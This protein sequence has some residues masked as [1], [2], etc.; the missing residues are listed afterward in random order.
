MVSASTLVTSGICKFD[1]WVLCNSFSSRSCA[2]IIS[3]QW[4]G[5]ETARITARFAP[6]CEAISTPRFTAPASPEI[7]VC[8]GEFRFAGEHTSP[9]AARLHASVTTAGDNPIIAAMAPCPAGTASCMYC[10]RLRTSCTASAN[11]SAPAAT[12]AEYSPKLWP[13]TKSGVMPLSA[14]TRYTATEQVKIAGCVLAVCFSSSSLPAKHIC[15]TENPNALSASSK[16]AR[17]A[18][19]F[20][21]SSLPMPGYCDACPGNTNAIFPISTSTLPLSGHASERELL[22][23]LFIDACFGQPGRDA[24]S[25]LHGVRVRTPVRYNAHAAHTQ[26]RRAARFRI[27]DLFLQSFQRSPGKQESHL[28]S[29]RT[30]DRFP[31]QPKNLKRQPFANLQRDISHKSIANDHIHFARKKVAAFDV[32]HKMHRALLQ[33]RIHFARQ[34]VALNLF[35]ADGK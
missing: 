30:I 23:D 24:D 14:S 21:A 17:A 32:A 18:G 28:R 29:Q 4:N 15:E 26:Q 10:P 31:Q 20:S 27:I 1:N 34:L 6:D 19:Y 11:F 2:G 16:T 9:S 5:A 22:F 13:A 33:S 7:T 3:A 8:S 35:L 25:I 12:S